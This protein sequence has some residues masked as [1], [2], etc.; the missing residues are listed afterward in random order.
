MPSL[1]KK[2][3]GGGGVMGVIGGCRVGDTAAGRCCRYSWLLQV[4]LVIFSSKLR[5]DIPR[6][7]QHPSQRSQMLGWEQN[8]API[9][10]CHKTSLPRGT[11]HVARDT[12]LRYA[13]RSKQNDKIQIPKFLSLSF[14][15]LPIYYTGPVHQIWCDL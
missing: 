3:R 11:W 1:S 9:P 14:R 2:A 12:L 4:K 7:L 6:G 13:G 5:Q 15:S 8:E 10:R